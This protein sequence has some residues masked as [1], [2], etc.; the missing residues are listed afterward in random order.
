MAWKLSPG[1]ILA[2][3]LH[4]PD[5]VVSVGLQHNNHAA[6]ISL[7]ERHLTW[8]PRR[9][10]SNKLLTMVREFAALG[11]LPFKTGPLC[12][13]RMW[14]DETGRMPCHILVQSLALLPQP[15]TPLPR[16]RTMRAVPI[17][18]GAS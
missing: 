14:E 16:H 1:F 10:P 3:E 15:G 4:E 5:A 17:L 6:L 13:G 7:I 8:D 9:S 11:S 12:E 2:S 18:A